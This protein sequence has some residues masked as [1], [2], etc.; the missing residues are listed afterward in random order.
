MLTAI[1]VLLSISLLVQLSHY[2]VGK[3]LLDLALGRRR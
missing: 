1:V 2:G 3:Q